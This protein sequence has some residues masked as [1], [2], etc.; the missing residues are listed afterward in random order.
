MN[1]LV[2]FYKG[3]EANLPQ[4]I[5]PGRILFTEDTGKLYI[6]TS[7][8][9][10]PVRKLINQ[11][12]TGTPPVRFLGYPTL[13]IARIGRR[14]VLYDVELL[15][16]AT[17]E[18][19]EDKTFTFEQPEL[20]QLILD[21]DIQNAYLR[22]SGTGYDLDHIFQFF[23][24]EYPY[25]ESDY[26][27]MEIVPRDEENWSTE[28][29]DDEAHTLITSVECVGDCW[30]MG[31]MRSPFKTASVNGQ[32]LTTA[33]GKPGLVPSYPT[34]TPL[35]YVLTGT[36][37]ATPPNNI[38]INNTTSGNYSF[39]AGSGNTSSGGW[40]VSMGQNAQAV[41]NNSVAI[42]QGAQANGQNGFACGRFNKAMTDG[43][44]VFVV[45]NGTAPG[46]RE[47]AF[48]VTFEGKAYGQSSYY[49]SGADYAEFIKPWA[50]GNINN[51]DRVG[52]MVTVKNGLLYKADIDDYII[53]VTSGNPSLIGNADEDYYWKYERDNFNRVIYEEVEEEIPKVDDQGNIVYEK[54]GKTIKRRKL[55][56]DYDP[57]LQDSYIERTDRPEWD[58]VG[59]RGIVRCRDDG[60][61]I[62]GGFCKCGGNGIATYSST[63]GFNTYYVIERIAENII[64]IEVK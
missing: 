53:G 50:D 61:C 18:M 40:S 2:K 29:Y 15:D 11:S 9:N 16:I 55:S 21:D 57:S 30:A 58:F 54:T 12:G 5:V 42:G 36:G 3:L 44:D 46:S 35:T 20:I 32:G 17:F 43:T 62:A 13:S 41:A 8:N 47:N 1:E 56:Q 60:T 48:R 51:E 63:Q 38:G 28:D 33:K 31:D 49:T 45:G 6:E 22:F 59:M 52:Y 19:V 34:G 10:T 64:S 7:V 14:D 24:N 4:T 23:G 39:S 25:G 26:I 27:L 37:W